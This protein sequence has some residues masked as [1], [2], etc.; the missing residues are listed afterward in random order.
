[1]FYWI[2]YFFL[3]L[4]SKIFFPLT[5]HGRNYI[6]PSGNVIIASNHISNL[7]PIILGLAY[8]RRISYLAKD[9]LFKNKIFSWVLFHVSTFPVKRNTAD[10]GAL[11]EALKRLSRGGSLV[12]FPEGTRK[13]TMGEKE[14]QQGIGFLAVKSGVPVIPAY[15]LGSDKVLPDGAKWLTPGKITVLLGEPI[16]FARPNKDYAHISSELMERI[17]SLKSSLKS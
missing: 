1:V 2:A 5:V 13:S 17:D 16:A 8:R 12:M 6:P 11:R 15:I 7:D 10:I 14:P 9:T 4:L 3:W